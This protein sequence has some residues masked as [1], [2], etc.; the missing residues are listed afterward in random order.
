MLSRARN[1]TE[2]INFNAT[3]ANDFD[4]E[5][6]DAV[7]DRRHRLLLHGV[8][9]PARWLQLALTGD[10]QSGTPVNRI[11]HFRDL[12]GSGE[13]YGTGFVGNHDRFPG[14]PR[15]GERLPGSFLLNAAGSAGLESGIGT[16]DARIEVFNLLNSMRV[17][18]Y[19]NGIPGGGARTQ[20][21][22]PG[23]P[24][25][26]QSSAPPRQFQLSIYWRP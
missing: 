10:Y 20:V 8:Y 6:A 2:D 16:V 17:S 3:V 26:F 22:W 24:M 15:N 1:D 12:D 4:R 5:W 7:N 14:V 19:A 13:I 25:I 9:A 18:G 11:A 23:D 21:G